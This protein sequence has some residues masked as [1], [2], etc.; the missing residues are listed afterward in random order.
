MLSTMK[1]NPPPTIIQSAL[2]GP[3]GI[4]NKLIDGINKF[5]TEDK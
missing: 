1:K 5:S 3:S 4:V 2:L